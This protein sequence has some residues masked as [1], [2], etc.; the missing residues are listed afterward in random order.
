MKEIETKTNEHL[1]LDILYV[2][3]ILLLWLKFIRILLNYYF[4]KVVSERHQFRM[5]NQTKESLTCKLR[6][7]P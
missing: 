5:N 1:Y 7:S 2:Y 6:I 3:R 4:F